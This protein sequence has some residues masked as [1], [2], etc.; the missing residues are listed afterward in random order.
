M[1][2]VVVLECAI[3]LLVKPHQNRHHLAQA[4][5]ALTI[6]LLQ[7]YSQRAPLP[8]SFPELTLPKHFSNG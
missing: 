3:V 2:Q 5:A 1:I 4:K 8:F 7:G 6:S